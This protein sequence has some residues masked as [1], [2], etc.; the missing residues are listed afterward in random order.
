MTTLIFHPIYHHSSI[1]HS[2]THISP[3]YSTHILKMV[4]PRPSIFRSA[5]W[6][7][8]TRTCGVR[9]RSRVGQQLQARRTYASGGDHGH[10]GGSDL[11][12]YV[13]RLLRN[14]PPI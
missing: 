1:E 9:A 2:I 10:S 12:W 7:Q 6:A 13:Y 3:L 11:P 4:L 14:W 8:T 5:L